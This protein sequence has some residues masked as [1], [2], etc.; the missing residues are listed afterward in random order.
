MKSEKKILDIL[1]CSIKL[2]NE[3]DVANCIYD[4]SIHKIKIGDNFW[5]VCNYERWTSNGKIELAKIT[6]KGL[7][8]KITLSAHKPTLKEALNVMFAY[9]DDL[10]LENYAIK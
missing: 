6:P 10:N 8:Y 2:W 1:P 9:Y 4:L 7:N 3:N 5:Y